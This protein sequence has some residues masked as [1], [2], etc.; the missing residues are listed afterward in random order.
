VTEAQWSL[1][2]YTGVEETLATLDRPVV[3]RIA[4][5]LRWLTQFAAVVRHRPLR[6]GLAGLYKLRVGDWRVIYQLVE[7]EHVVLV[8]RLGHRRDVYE[9]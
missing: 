2:F 6:A 9:E 3:E 4:R 5:K 8:L 1:R 7:D